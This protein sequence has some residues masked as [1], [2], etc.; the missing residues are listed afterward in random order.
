MVC[1]LGYKRQKYKNIKN[2]IFFAPNQDTGLI[3]SMNILLIYK[4]LFFKYFVCLF[5]G[6]AVK[7]ITVF[8]KLMSRKFR[9]YFCFFRHHIEQPLGPML[10]S[11]SKRNY[12]YL[13]LE[14]QLD[15]INFATST[16]PYCINRLW[17]KSIIFK[18]LYSGLK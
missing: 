8:K 13:L 16:P 3:F 15:S 6:Y 2:I 11:N 9:F 1:R 4:Q 12:I 17:N 5:D 7:D 10:F 14:D 18:S